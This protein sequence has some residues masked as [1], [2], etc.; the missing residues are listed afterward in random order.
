[1]EKQPRPFPTVFFCR[2]CYSFLNFSGD[3]DLALDEAE[4]Q[5]W[6]RDRATTICPKCQARKGIKKTIRRGLHEK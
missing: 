3:I 6:L 2:G 4:Q 5:G 1:M